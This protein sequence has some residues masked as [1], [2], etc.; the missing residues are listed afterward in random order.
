MSDIEQETRVG[1]HTGDKGQLGRAVHRS[2]VTHLAGPEPLG[3]QAWTEAER[4]GWREAGDTQMLA[5]AARWIWNLYEEHFHESIAVV[6]W[7]HS[8]GTIRW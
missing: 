7:F 5:G 3:W 6:D 4:R 1:E 2:Y 8:L